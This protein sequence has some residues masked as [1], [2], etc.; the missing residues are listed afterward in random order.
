[1]DDAAQRAE[2]TAERAA[3]EAKEGAGE[4]REAAGDAFAT[5][6]TGFERL[7]DEA[8]SGDAEAQEKLLDECRDALE[9]M[10]KDNDSRSEQMGALCQ[11]IRDADEGNAWSE[12]RE[13]YEQIKDGDSP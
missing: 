2:K 12:I 8:S 1:M 11:R 13:E 5:F 9:K 10:R 6:R 4:A 3:D 7:I